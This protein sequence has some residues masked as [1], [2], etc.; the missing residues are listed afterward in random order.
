MGADRPQAD[1]PDTG[2]PVPVGGE[3]PP[4]RQG[5]Q[6]RLGSIW[7]DAVSF[8]EALSRIDELVA[9]GRGGC[10]FTPNVDHVVTA[11]EDEE[12]RAAYEG[13]SLC[14]ADGKPLI[15]ASRLLGTPLPMK[16]SGSDLAWPL[17]EL[18]GRRGWRVYLL[19]STPEV[20]GAVATRLAR[21][22]GVRVAGTDSPL[23]RLDGPS[24]EG[25]AAVERVRV[26]SPEVLLV[27]LGTPK[28]ERWIHRVLPRI[29]PAVA[30]GVGAALDFVA[31]RV[32]RAPRW[33]SG[34]G[35]EWAFRLAQEPRRLAYR[36][37]VKDPRFIA[38]LARM[39]LEPRSRRIRWRG[40]PPAP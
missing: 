31:G 24:P 10:V 20:T 40:S 21:E 33:M 16:I 8:E 7:I 27:A 17:M 12:F 38:V 9:G 14:L 29:R 15:W 22:L 26:A 1:L 13:V 35:L 25:A 11:E 5:A 6:V 37:L 4:G 28:Q 34:A 32:R 30:I 36:Y 19:G 39:A 2:D 3:H 23:I 18:A